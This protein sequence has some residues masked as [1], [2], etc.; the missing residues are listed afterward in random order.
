MQREYCAP[1]QAPNRF[2]LYLLLPARGSWLRDD[3]YG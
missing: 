2:D 3:C 1:W